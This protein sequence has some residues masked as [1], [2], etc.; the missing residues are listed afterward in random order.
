M[1]F[2]RNT[3]QYLLGGIVLLVG[4]A[5]A[6]AELLRYEF[7]PQPQQGRLKVTL[8]WQT[9]NRTGS[10]LCVAGDWGT[11]RDVAGLL[12]TLRFGGAD[13]VRRSGNCW[14]LQHE[15]GAEIGVEYEVDVGRRDFDWD[16]AHHPITTAK[17][18][19]GMGSAFLMTPGVGGGLPAT[20]DVVLRWRLPD[21]WRAVCSWGAAPSVG[22]RLSAEDL[23]HSVYLAGE[24]ETLTVD[25]PGAD[26]LTVALPA[27]FDF[28]TEQFAALASAIVA[29]QVA[30]MQEP[31]FPPFVVTAIPVGKELPGGQR[32][33]GM[34]LYHSFALC[35]SPG[36]DLTEGI[37]HLFAH[38]LFHHWNGRRLQARQPER[39][40]Y[41][42]VE[43][44]TDYYALRILH[45]SG[46]WDAATYARWI[47]RHLREYD[48]NPARRATNREIERSYWRQR[49]TVGEVAYQRGLL[50]GLRWHH[51]A[52][53]R[54]IRSGIDKLMI[55]L[56]ER[57]RRGGFRIDNATLRSVGSAELGT[58]FGPEF[59]RY[60]EQAEIVEVPEDALAPALRGKVQAVYA[61]APGFDVERSVARRKVIGLK[62]DSAA[63][64]AGLRRGDELV[65][66][67]IDGDADTEI[68]LRV[69]R[70]EE[71]KTITYYPR[72]KRQDVLQ[73]APTE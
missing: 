6:G 13:A 4:A 33:V 46:R 64:E 57:A 59:D 22:A 10:T 25:V 18:F 44:F 30:F 49:D 42:F 48:A 17:F 65:A 1:R 66:W 73:F 8:R 70:G 63:A 14:Q 37:E 34:G 60:V 72:G 5:P 36:A 2:T 31:D 35:I 20:Y 50:L 3:W 45:E 47:N 7:T 11:V 68:R 23:L 58:W 32:L 40:V 52:R 62:R 19:H 56:L 67:Q 15:R 26:E 43:G 12:G 27:A 39:L 38:E 51:L 24:I 16:V 55:A 21:G 69:R 9:E 71:I 41:W 53:E 61:Y 54:G 28:D 29:G